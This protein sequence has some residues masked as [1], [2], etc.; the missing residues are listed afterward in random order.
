[1]K[2]KKACEATK[3]TERAIRLYLSKNLITPQQVNGIID[4][5]AE[6]IQHLQ[7]IAVLRQFDFTIEQIA[8]M[9]SDTST[10][11]A[12]LQIR[13]D[14]AKANHTHESE[15]Y[16]VLHELTSAQFGSIHSL[17]D[18][19]RE[20][21]AQ[22]PELFFYQMDEITAEERQLQRMEAVKALSFI[23][24]RTLLLRILIA[25]VC[26]ILAVTVAASIYLCQTRIEG[27]ISLSPITVVELHDRMLLIEDHIATVRT[28]NEAAIE[29]LGRDTITIPHNAYIK[30]LQEGETIQQGCQLTIRLTNF[31]LLKMGINPLQTMHTRSTDVNN[32]WM[33]YVLQTLFD[34]SFDKG[35]T[36]VI[37]EYTGLSPLL[38]LPEAH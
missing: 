16:E 38:T 28:S 24:K 11:P 25:T 9:I 21:R 8:G 37:Q 36:L 3:L 31:D 20:K 12:I 1:M 23:E 2:M 18:T 35:V 22:P 7:D 32:A 15:V 4:F 13:M 5:S 29:A 26:L 27:Y 34:H 33:R 30:P 19:I 6:D 17:A 14:S 10:I